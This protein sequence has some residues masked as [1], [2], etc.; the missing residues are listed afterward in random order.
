MNSNLCSNP[1]M[2]EVNEKEASQVEGGGVSTYL[3]WVW[4]WNSLFG[5]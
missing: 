5:R 1:V 3:F 4:G 2:T